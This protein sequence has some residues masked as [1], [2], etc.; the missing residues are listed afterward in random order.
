MRAAC[1]P[2]TRTAQNCKQGPIVHGK[3]VVPCVISQLWLHART[4]HPC[5]AGPQ[6]LSPLHCFVLL[7]RLEHHLTF[8]SWLC[9][10]RPLIRSMFPNTQANEFPGS[11]SVPV[12][13]TQPAGGRGVVQVVQRAVAE[14]LSRVWEF[15]MGVLSDSMSP[16]LRTLTLVVL[17]VFVVQVRGCGC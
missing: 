10:T 1:M 12:S 4:A 8:P 2:C 11:F 17:C 9:M 3:D 15:F 13:A 7:P 16:Q 5:A 6:F 14:W